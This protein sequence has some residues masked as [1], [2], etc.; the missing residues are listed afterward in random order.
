MALLS[1]I[2][3]KADVF[4]GKVVLPRLE[5][6]LVWYLKFSGQRNV[7]K[8]WRKQLASRVV[9]TMHKAEGGCNK[10]S[11]SFDIRLG[12]VREHYDRVQEISAMVNGAYIREL[13]DAL[14]DGGREAEAAFSRTS[15]HDIERRLLTDDEVQQLRGQAGTPPIINRVV[16]LALS[17]EGAILGTCAAT[18]AAPW[19]PS[20]VGSWGLLAVSAPRA[21]VGRALVEHCEEY[22]KIAMLDRIRIEYFFIAGLPSSES[23]RK[24]YEERLDYVCFKAPSTG[25]SYRGN[26]VRGEVEFR[27]CEKAVEIVNDISDGAISEKVVFEARRKRM[28]KFLL[29]GTKSD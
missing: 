22:I 19:C 9:G 28:A 6:L 2:R 21:G 7:E 26:E 15:P 25:R 16:F 11:L 24:W 20:G 14:L 27:H 18:L 17:K 1:W 13:K 12:T 4:L 8:Y 10:L 29:A 23:L 5:A 3:T